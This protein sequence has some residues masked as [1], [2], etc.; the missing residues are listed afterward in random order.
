MID[1]HYARL[2]ENGIISPVVSVSCKYKKP[3]SFADKIEIGVIIKDFNDAFLTV[4]YKMY[5]SET[6]ICE[7]ESVHCLMNAQ[8]R[9][10]RISRE[11]PE[12]AAFLENTKHAN[13]T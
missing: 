9:I 2:E 1:F 10:I 13:N 12:F 8:G 3:T 4:G 7:A 11:Q 5:K 6:L